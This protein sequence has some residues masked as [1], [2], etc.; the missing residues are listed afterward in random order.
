MP[1]KW[2]RLSFSPT[3]KLYEDVFEEVADHFNERLIKIEEKL[4]LIIYNQYK[5]S[6]K[7]PDGS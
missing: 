3:G 6:P 5:L 4:D 2:F 7:N 1:N